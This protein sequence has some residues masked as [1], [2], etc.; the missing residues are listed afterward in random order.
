M[1]NHSTVPPW[2]QR[3][4]TATH[5]RINGRTRQVISG[6][7]LRSGIHP[8]RGT[9]ALHHRG[10]LSG[11]LTGRAC[12][13]QCLCSSQLSTIPA[14]CQGEAKKIKEIATFFRRRKRF[15]RAP[16]M[17]IFFGGKQNSKIIVY[18]FTNLCYTLRIRCGWA[19]PAFRWGRMNSP[20]NREKMRA[21]FGKKAIQG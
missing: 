17:G 12:L 11:N 20:V 1:K 4:R 10:S 3:I 21:F 19:D 15:P 7:R 18:F 9:G 2:L 16:G 5:W 13:H 6:L 14:P 8:G